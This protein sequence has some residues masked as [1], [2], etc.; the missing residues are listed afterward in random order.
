MARTKTNK[1]N[2]KHTEQQD[3]TDIQN[4]L[5][6]CFDGCSIKSDC[7]MW[8]LQQILS[9]RLDAVND[10]H[11]VFK[12]VLSYSKHHTFSTFIAEQKCIYFLW[13]AIWYLRIR[14]YVKY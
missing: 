12:P 3:V 14:V 4:K 2:T 11:W 9:Y 8:F 5:F 6:L 7:F 13:L 10:F 1:T